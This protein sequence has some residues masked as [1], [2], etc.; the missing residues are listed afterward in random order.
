MIISLESDF[1]HEI[2]AIKRMQT[3]MAFD[4]SCKVFALLLIFKRGE[5][6]NFDVKI[7]DCSRLQTCKSDTSYST[8]P[9]LSFLIYKIGIM[10]SLN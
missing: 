6:R 2:A 1:R 7:I 8:S 10:I 4:V 5:N 9:N 3:F